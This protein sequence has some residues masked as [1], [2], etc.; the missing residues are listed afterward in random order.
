MRRSLLLAVAVVCLAQVPACTKAHGA[1]VRVV[2]TTLD[3]PR[4]RTA[5]CDPCLTEQ[6]D[7]RLK[8]GTV[9]PDAITVDVTK[10]FQKIDGFGLAMTD[11]SAYLIDQIPNDR[12]QRDALMRK[13]FSA[14]SGIGVSWMRMT[15]GA[16]DFTPVKPPWYSYRPT[17]ADPFDVGR[18]RTGSP[19]GDYS[20]I[21]PRLR[22]AEVLSKG[23]ITFF[24]NP[25]SAPPW[26]K[27]NNSMSNL[28]PESC[29]LGYC[30]AA[31]SSEDVR[32][33][34]VDYF[35]DF[36]KAYAAKGVPIDAV[37]LQN[38]PNSR[39]DYP[40]GDFAPVDQADFANRLKTGLAAQSPPLTQQVLVEMTHPRDAPQLMANA[41]NPAVIDGISYHCYGLGGP[42]LQ[43]TLDAVA[44]FRAAYPHK[45]IRETECTQDRSQLWPKAIDILIDHTRYGANSVAAW[46][47]ALDPRGGPHSIQCSEV[48]AGVCSDANTGSIMSAPVVISGRAGKATARFT[49]EYYELGH[50]T[51]YVRPG[52]VRVG[53]TPLGAAG[54]AVNNVAFRNVDGSKVLVVH[55]GRRTPASFAV[56]VGGNRHFAV[57]DLP[58]DAIATYVW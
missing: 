32:G 35:V 22:Q 37:G 53:S 4:S 43:E 10:R 48:R 1:P 2:L 12:G 44:A 47:V 51:K 26:M 30:P 15:I 6:H 5:A 45:S 55:N 40:S 46:N 9:G 49:R 56:N 8:A 39:A 33:E 31:S 54:D 16:S 28:E 3:P 20:H 29:I 24:A 38:E 17:P 42:S 11:A 19:K 23:R 14:D 58:P 25:H 34:Y 52:A 18:A 21:I 36:I 57:D 13:L 27:L 50:F 7:L 41:P